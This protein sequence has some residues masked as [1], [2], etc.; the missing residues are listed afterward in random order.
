MK[1][2]TFNDLHNIKKFS[3]VIFKANG[4]LLNDLNYLLN[5]DS[6]SMVLYDIYLISACGVVLTVQMHGRAVQQFM[7]NMAFMN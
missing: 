3:G 2:F 6:S 5:M 7:G 1:L 4:S